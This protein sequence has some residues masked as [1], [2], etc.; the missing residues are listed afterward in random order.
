MDITTI[1]EV[2]KQATPEMIG[3]LGSLTI[4]AAYQKIKSLFIGKE[5]SEDTV[6][7]KLNE[8]EENRKLIE[9][10]AVEIRNKNI[11]SNDGKLII[12]KNVWTGDFHNNTFNL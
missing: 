10:F 8:S 5:I 6:N 2:L 12:G 1:T 11:S 4:A 7:E 9:E 3:G